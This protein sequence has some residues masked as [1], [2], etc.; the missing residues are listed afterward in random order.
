[1]EEFI[2]FEHLVDA[3][4]AF[5]AVGS[6]GAR[7]IAFFLLKKDQF[8]IRELVSRLQNARAAIKRCERCNGW[9][10]KE[11][12]DI[13]ASP[14]RDRSKICVVATIDDMLT[15][16]RCQGYNGLYHVLDGELSRKKNVDPETLNLGGLVERANDPKV[17]E[18]LIATNFTA[19]G[20]LTANY[21]AL[22]LKDSR[23]SVCR[24]S[25][26]L[27]INSSIDYADETTLKSAIENRRR[28]K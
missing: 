27:P 26:G 9:S 12:C 18:V 6:K 28:I 24:I 10:K 11:L 19:D 16:E 21:V 2:E 8:F 5:P 20:E 25:L 14:L 1:M 22:L 13:C 15:I 7:R 4:S 3:I 17:S 23:A